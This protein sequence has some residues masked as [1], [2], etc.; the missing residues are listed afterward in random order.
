[1]KIVEV[2]TELHGIKRCCKYG[3]LVRYIHEGFIWTGSVFQW[4]NSEMIVKHAEKGAD[5]CD[6]AQLE[7][8]E[9]MVADQAFQRLTFQGENR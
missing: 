8:L 5:L 2:Q 7:N 1:M 6:L 3:G 9:C 4:P